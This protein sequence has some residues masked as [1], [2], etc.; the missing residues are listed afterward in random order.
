MNQEIMKALLTGFAEL[1]SAFFDKARK[2]GFSIM[3]L[4]VMSGGLL[5]KTA[6]VER[7]CAEDMKAMR[8]DRER[9]NGQWAEALNNAR[10]D[11][12][13]CDLR[14]QELAIKFAELS[15]RVQML[16]KETKKR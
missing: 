2:Q 11:F 9:E 6:D 8:E 4:V 1:V 7:S 14:R 10:R 16:E 12:L 3:L 5:Y 15:I 13:E